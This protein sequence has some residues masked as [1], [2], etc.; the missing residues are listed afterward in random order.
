METEKARH[1]AEADG[2]HLQA[3]PFGYAINFVMDYGNGRQM[4]IS[5]TLPLGAPLSEFNREL[6]KLREATNRQQAYVILRDRETKLKAERKMVLILETSLAEYEKELEKEMERLKTDPASQH[7]GTPGTLRTQVSAQVENMRSQALNFRM[8]KSQE[9]KQHQA[10]VEICE[11][12]I[13]SVKAEI[14]AIDK[15]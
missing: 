14:E 8:Q 3:Q 6:D 9:I 4:T 5:G 1:I 10:E 15:G 12:I 7:K 13:A 2:K 11:V